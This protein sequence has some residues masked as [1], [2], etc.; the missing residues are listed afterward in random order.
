MKI[1]VL[2]FASL[3]DRV[4]VREIELELPLKSRVDDA[5]TELAERYPALASARETL[6]VAV[7]L[8]YVDSAHV[9]ADHDELALI[10][11]VSGG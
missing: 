7:N 10:P 5:L 2:F 8:A 9:L 11:P 6:A 1:K 4:G 3:A